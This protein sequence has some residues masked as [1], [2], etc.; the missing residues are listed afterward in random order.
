MYT[1][2]PQKIY[3]K[4]IAHFKEFIGIYLILPANR[5]V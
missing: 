5:L 1:M 3:N 4:S 2:F